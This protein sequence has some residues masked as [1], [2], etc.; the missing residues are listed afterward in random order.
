MELL[1][2]YSDGRMAIFDTGLFDHWENKKDNKSYILEMDFEYALELNERDGVYILAFGVMTIKPEI[3]GES[4]TTCE[5]SIMAPRARKAE[6]S[7]AFFSET[8]LRCV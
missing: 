6:Y 4:S 8:T 3:T 1:L 7:Y 5:F 2:N